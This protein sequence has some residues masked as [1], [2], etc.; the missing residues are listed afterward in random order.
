MS[1]G[2]NMLEFDKET[3]D[4]LINNIE[5]IFD[6]A[7]KEYDESK[8]I[9]GYNLLILLLFRKIQSLEETINKLRKTNE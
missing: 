8:S 7:N 4:K 1:I 3:I 9:A 2:G 5:R 6:Q